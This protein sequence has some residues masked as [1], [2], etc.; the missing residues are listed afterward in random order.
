MMAP[1][2]RIS[3]D[4]AEACNGE[5]KLDPIKVMWTG[6]MMLAFLWLAPSNK[7]VVSICLG[8]GLTYITLLFGHS[9]GMHRML[10]HR[11]FKTQKWL[12][13][14]L[15]YLGTLVGIGGPSAVIKT[16]DTRDW[17]QR[18]ENCHDFFSH[19][20]GYLRDISWQLFYKFEFENP[21]ELV[22][23]PELR[24]DPFIKHIDCF[25]RVHQIGFA[26]VLFLIGGLPFVV[27]GICFRVVISII[28]HWTVT[29]I[30]HNPGPG[31]WDVITNGVQAS[32]LG[33]PAWING[34]LTHGECWH[35]NHHAFPESAR[36]GLDAG[37][38]D[39]AAWVIEKLERC[40]L[41]YDVGMPRKVISDLRPRAP[42]SKSG[43]L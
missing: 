31:R 38:V 35:N 18:A 14:L 42:L 23:E 40:G 26:V 41:V 4:Q 5:V 34:L 3:A 19:R 43:K 11:S 39:P 1:V 16:H 2:Y 15:L 20:R 30:C 9:V 27:W 36:I 7:N 13:N 28:G 25:W 21:P 37:Q 10:I 8:L 24:N 22:I 6:G 32:N 29:Y 17:A 33:L 12:R